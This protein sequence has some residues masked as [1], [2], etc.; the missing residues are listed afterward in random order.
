VNDTIPDLEAHITYNMFECAIM[1]LISLGPGLLI[2]KLDLKEAFRHIPICCANWH[3]LGFTWDCRFYFLLLTF[4]LHSRPYILN[5]FAEALHW[6]IQQ[7]IP[8]Y[9]L[10]Y[11]DNFIMTFKP[12]PPIHMQCSG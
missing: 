1:D 9:L 4:G 10:H 8:S 7:H 12:A 3:H 2:V 11:L 5:L 6:I